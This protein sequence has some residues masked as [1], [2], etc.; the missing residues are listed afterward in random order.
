[1]KFV[2]FLQ[3]T[4]VLLAIHDLHNGEHWKEPTH[5]KPERFLTKEGNLI[6]DEWLMPFGCGNKLSILLSLYYIM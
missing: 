3:G 2:N 5:F 4:F 1:M 6:Q